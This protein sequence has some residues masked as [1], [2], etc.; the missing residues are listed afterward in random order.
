MSTSLSHIVDNLSEGFHK[1]TNCKLNLDY[2]STKDN[3]LILRCFR[4]KKIME[5]TLI[6]N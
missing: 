1:C 5:K 3:Q 6:K 2:I 4:C